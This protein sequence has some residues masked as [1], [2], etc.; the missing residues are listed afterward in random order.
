MRFVKA[1]GTGND[2]VL[3]PDPVGQLK[4]SPPLVRALCDRHA[5]I[6]GDGVIR[7]APPPPGSQ[8]DAFMDY[9]NADGSLAEMCG[10]GLR[11]MAKQLIDHAEDWPGLDHATIAAAGDEVPLRIDTRAGERAVTGWRGPDGRVGEVEVVL[12]SPDVAAVELPLVVSGEPVTVTTLSFGNPHAVLVVDD[13]DHA[14]V[15]ALGPAI[16]S[17]PEFPDGANV[18]FISVPDRDKVV[19]R[20][21]ERGV[22]ETRSSGTGAAAMAAAA[23]LRGLAGRDVTVWLPGGELRVR[24]TPHTLL[25]SGP[26]VEVGAGELDAGWLAGVR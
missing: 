1:H 15:A 9:W 6:G 26:A 16:A 25:L 19:G 4:L 2:F 17:H 3:L 11:C 14:A 18:E 10:N 21:F 24:W 8:A 7:M 23:A 13:V 22:G 5:G 20:I 12:G